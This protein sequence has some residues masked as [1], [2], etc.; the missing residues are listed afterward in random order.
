MTVSCYFISILVFCK[1]FRQSLVCHQ[2]YVF[3]VFLDL[4]TINF[5]FRGESEFSYPSSPNG[6]R[7]TVA[8]T[9]PLPSPPATESTNPTPSQSSDSP[10]HFG[11]TTLQKIFRSLTPSNVWSDTDD[12]V[13][14]VSDK[15]DSDSV[16]VEDLT[17]YPDE[18]PAVVEPLKV[19]DSPT[20]HLTKRGRETSQ[21][22]NPATEAITLVDGLGDASFGTPV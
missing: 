3:L 11:V 16:V 2:W 22:F 12:K 15:P 4:L 7:C 9:K 5:D 1:H 14:S 19:A 10:R 13:I 8:D 18:L 17:V 20:I 6:S 21:L